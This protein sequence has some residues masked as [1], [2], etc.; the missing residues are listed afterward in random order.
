MI[1][2]II[3]KFND[4]DEK[5]KNIMTKGFKFSFAFFIFSIL[6]LIMYNFYM[7]PILYTCGTILFKTSFIFF[8]DFII[9]GFG[10]DKIKKQMA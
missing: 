6:I 10:F 2:M 8:A 5:V 9:I 3:N 1:K 7:L 4:L